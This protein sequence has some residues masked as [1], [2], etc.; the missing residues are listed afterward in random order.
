MTLTVQSGGPSTGAGTGG[1]ERLSGG[2]TALVVVVVVGL[3]ILTVIV[4]I[5]VTRRCKK[6]MVCVLDIFISS[7]KLYCLFSILICALENIAL[8]K[9]IF[10][11]SL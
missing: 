6:T 8:K 1:R 11:V 3:L 7:I 5:I 4:A 10:N 2:H 9:Y